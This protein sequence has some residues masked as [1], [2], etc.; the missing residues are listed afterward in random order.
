MSTWKDLIIGTLKLTD[1]VKRLNADVS[2][3]EDKVIDVDKRIVRLE[4]MIEI[5][6]NQRLSKR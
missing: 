3:L 2:K 1:E 5:S 6:E 4:T